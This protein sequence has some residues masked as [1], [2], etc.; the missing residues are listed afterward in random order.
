PGRRSSMSRIPI[1]ARLTLLFALVMACV[2]VG[3]GWF[4]AAKV[5]GD[6][7]RALDQDLRAR[8]QDLK[9]SIQHG[10]SLR[11]SRGTLVEP[12]ESFAQLLD[13]NGALLDSTPTVGGRGLLRS[14]ELARTETVPFF[15]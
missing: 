5:G 13:H 9:A 10:G 15:V 11:A 8:T 4:V 14:D 2:L 12:G 3:V 7:S 1:R 6:L